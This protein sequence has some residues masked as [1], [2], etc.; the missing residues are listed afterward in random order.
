MH[1]PQTEC[2]PGYTKSCA[3]GKP[4]LRFN[5]KTGKFEPP[6]TTCK[7]TNGKDSYPIPV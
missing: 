1:Q 5:P 2:K 4:M 7:C 6:P 3:T